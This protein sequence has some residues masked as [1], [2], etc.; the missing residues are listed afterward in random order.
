MDD[1]FKSQY[2][3]QITAFVL[4]NSLIYCHN[5]GQHNVIIIGEKNI[6]LSIQTRA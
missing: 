6:E 3:S 5:L 4:I 1:I 2:I